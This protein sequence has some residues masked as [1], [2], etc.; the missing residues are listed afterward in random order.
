MG[1]RDE[2]LD[3]HYDMATPDKKHKRRQEFLDQI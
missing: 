2:V 1:V 3:E